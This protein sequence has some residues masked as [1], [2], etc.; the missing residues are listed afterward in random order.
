MLIDHFNL[1]IFIKNFAQAQTQTQ[2]ELGVITWQQLLVKN[3]HRLEA[4]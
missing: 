4:G 2:S 1:S 3:Q